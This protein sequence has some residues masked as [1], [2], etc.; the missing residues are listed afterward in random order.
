MGL[1]IPNIL[2]ENDEKISGGGA[3]VFMWPYLF[4]VD[5]FRLGEILV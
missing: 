5:P 4:G 1:Q 2:S 3:G